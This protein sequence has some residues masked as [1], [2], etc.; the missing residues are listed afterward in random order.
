MDLLTRQDELRAEADEV[1]DSLGLM[2]HLAVLGEPF[3]VGSAAL[4]LMVK[5]D[6][7][8][9]V[10]VRELAMPP[11]AA[12]GAQLAAHENVRVVQIRDDTGHWNTDPNYP[13][14]LYLGVKY[15]Q[16]WNLDLWFVD[17]PTRQPDLHHAVAFP[18]RLTDET[19]TAILRIKHD[20]P[21][22]RSLELYEA[23]LDGGVRTVEEYIRWRENR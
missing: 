14:G 20:F 17:D 16:E 7:D 22:Y 2:T 11:V 1:L 8:I 18:P 12:L 9:T 4:G 13:D 23:V 10:V 21:E 19:R 5:R 3:R 15:G 6:I